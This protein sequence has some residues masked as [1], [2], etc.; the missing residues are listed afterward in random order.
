ME[1]GQ[2]VLKQLETYSEATRQ[3]SLGA[4]LVGIIDN[5]AK[6]QLQLKQYVL[7]KQSYERAFNIWQ[8]NKAFDEKGKK[9]LSASI[10]HQ[11]G[12]VAQEQ[13]EWQQARDYYQQALDIKIEFN[14]RYSQAGTYHQLGIVAQEQR[15]WQQARDY[16]QQAL[17][18]YIEFNDRYSQAST[19]HQLGR[20][21]QEQ[22]EWQQARDYYQQALDIYIEFNDRYEQASTYHQLGIVAQEQRE[23]QQARDYYQQAL[24][25]YIEFNDRYEQAST[26]HQLGIVAQDQREWQQARDYYQQALDIYIE[27]N[28]R[29]SQAGTYHQLGIVA[30]DQR[31]WQQARDYYQQALDIKIEFNDRYSQA[32]TYHNL[33]IVA[34]EQREWQ[35][36]RDYY[37][38]ALDIYIEFNDR[39]EQAGTYHQLGRVAQEQR[40]WQQ[41]RA[42]LPA[43]PCRSISSSTTAT[44]RQAPIT[45]WVESLRSNASGSKL[46]QYYQQALHIK[47][48]FNDRYSQASTYHQLGIVAQEQREWQQARALLPASP[49]TSISSST[50]ATPGKHLSPVGRCRSGATRVAASRAA[51]T[52]KPLQIYIEFN[53]RYEQAGTYHQLGIVA[54]EQREWQQAREN[55]LASLEIFIQY[56]DMN[57]VAVVVRSLARLWQETNDTDILTSTLSMSSSFDEEERYFSK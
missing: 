2:L 37:Q 14:D 57:G 16:Y 1:L 53:D 52:S 55:F 21:A 11:L 26:Y 4:E 17:D 33:G 35:Q 5:I 48:E 8:E 43:S 44:L 29:Y 39:Y 30:Q 9:H 51:T 7:A 41:A 42:L 20:V 47:I 34:Q 15:E 19:Y 22:R 31:E 18:I 28:D 24:D 36:A 23:W 27:F 12:R 25:I 45:S 38:Q 54:Q 50:T 6:R 32:G 13:R 46:E 3:G 10:Y 56:Q 49:C 40:E